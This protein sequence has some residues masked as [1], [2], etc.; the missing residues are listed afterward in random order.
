MW[1]AA[2]CRSPAS[3]CSYMLQY[4]SIL[5]NDRK[6]CTLSMLLGIVVLKIFCN[7]NRNLKM[8]KI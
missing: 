5:P 1:L 2:V 7:N 4:I 8:K 6:Y 3:V